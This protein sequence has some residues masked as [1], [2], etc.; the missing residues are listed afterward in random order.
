MTHRDYHGDQNPHW[1]GDDVSL[2]AMH[3]RV[4]A[5][6][7]TPDLC[8][9]CGNTDPEV[10]RFEWAFN[11]VGDRLN[12]ND[13]MRLCAACHRVFDQSHLPHGSAHHN[14][15]LVE[16]QVIELKERYAAGGISQRKLAKQFKISL[17]EVSKI[18][19]G[20]RWK[21]TT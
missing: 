15:K 2:S 20:K 16:A 5:A 19:T 7:G 14:A 9:F 10:S 6:R 12:V 18:L 8:E 17:A 1:L 21:D 11:N 4:R 3:G 13:Y